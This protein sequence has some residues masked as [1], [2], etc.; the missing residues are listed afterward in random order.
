MAVV[1]ESDKCVGCGACV[2]TCP[3]EALS[4]NGDKVVVDANKCIDCSACV[5]ACPTDAISM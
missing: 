3:V 4:M 2:E 5:G 1:I